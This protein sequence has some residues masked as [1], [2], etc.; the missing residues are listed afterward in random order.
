MTHKRLALESDDGLDQSPRKRMR[1]TSSFTA[2]QVAAMDEDEQLRHIMEM[3]KMDAEYQKSKEEEEEEEE[4]KRAIAQSLEEMVPVTNGESCAVGSGKGKRREREV[5]VE[6]VKEVEPAAPTYALTSNK[7]TGPSRAE[8]EKER[9]ARAER[10]MS[11]KL[12]GSAQASAG[13]SSHLP[14][15]APTSTTKS[16]T[17]KTPRPKVPVQNA[18]R[19]KGKG[20]ATNEPRYWDWKI[21]R[22][23]NKHHPETPDA[24]RFCD[25]VG[26]TDDL[27]MAISSTYCPEPE[28][29]FRH[30]PR[31]VTHPTKGRQRGA[32]VLLIHHCGEDEQ[33]TDKMRDVMM[34]ASDDPY[35]EG[36]HVLYPSMPTNT[37]GRKSKGCHHIK[38][39][40]FA[41]DDYLRI[42][43]PTANL[44]SYDWDFIENSVFVM[45]F[46]ASAS[47]SLEEELPPFIADFKM[48]LEHF[49]VAN[50]WIKKLVGGEYDFSSL[51]TEN[52]PQLVWSFAGS[53][54]AD[55]AKAQ[56]E[57]GGM[58]RLGNA[59][60]AL[61][62]A[63]DTV[64]L[65]CQGSSIGNYTK[66]WFTIFHN[67]AT[68]K[69][70]STWLSKFLQK[71]G[72]GPSAAWPPVEV[73]FPTDKTVK[74]SHEGYA[75]GFSLF[76]QWGTWSRESFPKHAFRKGVSRREGIVMHVKTI[77][78][79]NE[80]KDDGFIYVGSHNFTPAAWGNLTQVTK[81][82]WKSRIDP[83]PF[84]YHISNNELGVVLPI[85]RPKDKAEGRSLEEVVNDTVAWKR[86]LEKYGQRDEPWMLHSW[87]RRME[88]Q[89]AG[90]SA[91]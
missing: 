66:D 51:R 18:T 59:I 64:R 74:E 40:I 87:Q 56:E 32:R 1:P 34:D 71:G 23:F 43:I 11:S 46:P 13:S 7:G 69:D 79:I 82:E 41:H 86:P 83:R 35:C 73:I 30:F 49:N 48:V 22:T 60:R 75:G 31:F 45:D 4:L 89:Q 24:V 3:S 70:P 63:D 12:S 17:I 20:R 54:R 25:L 85:L 58:F 44:V 52:A 14:S 21:V 15:P 42:C 16:S 90:R 53:L 78:G 5:S 84:N 36:F 47:I 57:L 67:F 29:F 38:F 28:W 33:V 81:K 88:K 91:Q 2:E 6:E 10:A 65:E 76:C 8:M 27:A 80:E 26:N 9:L 39:A 50:S 72:A 61:G 19:D 77:L 55:N 62:K 37:E 68:G